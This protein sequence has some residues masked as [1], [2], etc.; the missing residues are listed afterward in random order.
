MSNHGFGAGGKHLHTKRFGESIF[1]ALSWTTVDPHFAD[2]VYVT[3]PETL[4]GQN[5]PAADSAAAE[6]A[7]PQ[8]GAKNPGQCSSQT[9]QELFNVQSAAV[10]A[11]GGL[12]PA[13]R[14]H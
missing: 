10:P 2:I 6:S 13:V 3:V 11:P 4:R 9:E 1:P 8:A 14:L 7:A 12:N 5:A